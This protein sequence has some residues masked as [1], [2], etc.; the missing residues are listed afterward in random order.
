MVV[1]MNLQG[2]W[3]LLLFLPIRRMLF[4]HT[5]NMADNVGYEEG[6]PPVTSEMEC[7]YPRFFIH[8]FIKKVI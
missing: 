2:G 6:D 3:A 8:P 1:Y 4:R 5:A 7:G